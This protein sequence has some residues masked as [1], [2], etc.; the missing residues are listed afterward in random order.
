M[1]ALVVPKRKEMDELKL[2][3]VIVRVR[4]Y[5]GFTTHYVLEWTS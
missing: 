3:L 4:E 5:G 1:E 2:E